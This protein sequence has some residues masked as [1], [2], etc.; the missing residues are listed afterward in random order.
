MDFGA[1]LID[2][3]KNDF[4]EEGYVYQMGV[5]PIRVDILMGISGVEFAE[6]WDR[7]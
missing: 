7:G 4:A 3:S 5:P 6:A 1:P 2:M